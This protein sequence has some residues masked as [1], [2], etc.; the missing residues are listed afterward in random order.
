[1]KCIPSLKL[2]SYVKLEDYTLISVSFPF[3][4]DTRLNKVIF[5]VVLSLSNIIVNDKWT[6][7]S[8]LVL[9]LQN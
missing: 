7:L 8:R 6:C 5:E 1:M 2:L 3:P 9:S 4:V